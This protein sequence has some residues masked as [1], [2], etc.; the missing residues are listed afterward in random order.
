[1]A[2]S[3]PFKIDIFPSPTSPAK[4]CCITG[5]DILVVAAEGG[6]DIMATPTPIAVAASTTT[7][8]N[9][10]LSALPRNLVF[11]L[12]L[13]NVS[14]RVLYVTW[15]DGTFEEPESTMSGACPVVDPTVFDL[16]RV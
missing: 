13:Q 7:Q 8:L 4:Y 14:T 15:E 12:I 6:A 2:L 9:K 3:L 11:E 16:A 1:M 10:Q 5:A